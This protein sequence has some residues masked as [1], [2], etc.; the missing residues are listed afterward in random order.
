MLTLLDLLSLS[1]RSTWGHNGHYTTQKHFRACRAIRSHW[2]S[3]AQPRAR[4]THLHFLH[5][6]RTMRTRSI[7]PRLLQNCT[8][9]SFLL[10]KHI[11]TPLLW[12]ILEPV[13]QSWLEPRWYD[14][15]GSVGNRTNQ[16]M[17][18]GKLA[19]FWVVPF[20]A[21]ACFPIFLC[22]PSRENLI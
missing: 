4:R 12:V 3:S 7:Y 20:M 15:P 11:P 16:P 1:L 17:C 13:G 21:E 10:D 18:Q 14:Y 8:S 6:Y 22:F 19:C 2:L 5:S 9:F